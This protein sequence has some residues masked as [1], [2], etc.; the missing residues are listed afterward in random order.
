MR[1]YRE[2][3]FGDSVSEH[4]QAAILVIICL[5]GLSRWK[6]GLLTLFYRGALVEGELIEEGDKQ[7]KYS[8]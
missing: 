1:E 2:Q 4:V 7:R 6:G 8:I 3:K 5:W